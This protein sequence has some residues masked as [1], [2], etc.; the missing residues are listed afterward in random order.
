MTKIAG[1]LNMLPKTFLR[2]GISNPSTKKAIEIY[3]ADGNHP[4]FYRNF[5]GS[6]DNGRSSLRIANTFS[7][8]IVSSP[9]L[10]SIIFSNSLVEG[11]RERALIV[12][13]PFLPSDFMVNFVLAFSKSSLLAG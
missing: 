5:V 9:V 1:A 8:E 6:S 3:R 11:G 2:E 7:L 4:K 13:A 12:N 10:K